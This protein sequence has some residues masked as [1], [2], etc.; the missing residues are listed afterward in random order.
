MVS[1][2]E[3]ERAI[4]TLCGMLAPPLDEAALLLVSYVRLH[5]ELPARAQATYIRTRGASSEVVTAGWSWAATE[6]YDALDLA[7]EGGLTLPGVPRGKFGSVVVPF[8]AGIML[9]VAPS[10]S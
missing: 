8:V 7:T 2:V 4:L 10:T 5:P 3:E 6:T 9:G 1:P